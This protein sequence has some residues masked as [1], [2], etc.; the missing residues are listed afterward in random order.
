MPLSVAPGGQAVLFASS[1]AHPLIKTGG[2]ADVAA[3]LPAALRELG[4]DARLIIPAY[5]QAKRLV[6][7]LRV[8]SDLGLK[9]T[10][11]PVSL[12]GGFLPDRDLPVFLVEAPAY[13]C[14][15]GN[16]YTDVSGGDW[17]DNPE[18][19]LLF[20]RVLARVALGLPTLD[21]RPDVLHCNDWQT[22][23]APVF[24]N[25]YEERPATVFTV[26]NLAY[27]G[28]FDR[29]TFDRLGLP[30]ALWSIG[31]VEFH[32]RMSFLKGGIVFSDRINTVSPTYADEV[33]TAHFGCGLD[34][35][36]RQLGSR[37]R[38]I[39]NGIDYRTWNPLRDRSLVQN[40]DLDSLELKA[41]NKLALQHQ[42]DLPHDEQSLVL[43]H[44]GR[45][46]EQKG[47]DMILELLPR[48]IEQGHIQLVV[49]GE[50][51]RVLE[52]RLLDQAAQHPQHLSVRIGY[53]E[54]RAHLI[55]AGSDLFLM[56]S[57]FEPCGLNQMYSL[58]YGTVP[59]VRRTGGLADTVVDA[60][61]DSL[62]NDEATGFLFDSAD[63][64]ALW[65]AIERALRLH[66]EEPATWRRLMQNGM[67]RDLSWEASAKSYQAF[68]E[69]ALASRAQQGTALSA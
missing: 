23:L 29:A 1:E 69:E 63:A 41:A 14:R 8:I 9:G 30:P 17:G 34:G 53:D 47:V 12:L 56:P 68:Y 28:I 25:R 27:Q 50:G 10:Q 6:R 21:W 66:R 44:I 37:F 18:R 4:H 62:A 40:Y 43:G 13:F 22:G 52:Q 49:Q 61:P 32:Q 36:L 20:A 46:V 7:E 2:L 64:E 65:S 54:A 5:P 55:E 26:H 33:R 45:L 48:L 42:F 39:L 67:T 35:L 3:S 16:P 51:D 58:R 57:R 15:E 60:T 59:V 38:G 11:G 31:G 19:F 24:L